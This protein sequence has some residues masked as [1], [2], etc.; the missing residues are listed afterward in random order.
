ML[1]NKINPHTLSK[2]HNFDDSSFQL[3]QDI[4]NEIGYEV[5]LFKKTSDGYLREVYIKNQ[6]LKSKL[7]TVV[8][9]AFSG[10]GIAIGLLLEIILK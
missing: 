5:D 9:L 2:N 7:E 3:N 1:A 10:W 6:K 4:D 8:I